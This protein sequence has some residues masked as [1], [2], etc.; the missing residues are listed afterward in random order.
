MKYVW[1]TAIIV[2]T[3][4][5]V[6]AAEIKAVVGDVPIS[7]YDV[8]E[9][10]RL[11]RLQQPSQFQ[12][13]D[14]ANLDK[15][16]LQA[17]IDEYIKRQEA[18]KQGFQVSDTD[19]REAIGRLEQQ[20]NMPAGQM[21]EL[22][23]T[24]DIR[25]ETLHQQVRSDLLW[26][27]ILSKNKASLEVVTN[28]DV[29]RKK[30]ALK[31]ELAKPMYLLAEIVVPTKQEA[32]NIIAD[33]RRGKTFSD[34][35]AQKSKATS[36]G[37]NGLL[38][39]V[40]SDVYSPEVMNAVDALRV[41]EMTSP[42]QVD[43]GWLIVLLLDKQ[44]G[45]DNGEMIIWDLAQL[46]TPKNKTVG[47]IPTVFKMTTCEEFMGFA[48]INAVKG[49]ARRGM[50]DPNQMPPQLKQTLNTQKTGTPIGPIQ[51]EEGDLFFMKCGE[52]K[53]SIL[54]SDEMIRSALEMEKMDKLS[55]KLLRQIKRYV[56]VEY[57]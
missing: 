40:K 8:S 7:E 27:Q 15:K 17:L 48:D 25:L 29:G 21:A 43:G 42:I 57:K 35:A 14:D 51:T 38:G 5:G 24:A 47:Y 45:A 18:E 1:M 44:A 33:I 52:Q 46:A 30:A 13:V 55:E 20:N 2:G 3:A 28:K 11:M 12:G 4:F 49:T 10:V 23:K 32:E 41:N 6:N 22:L 53:Q 56:V 9:R 37:S 50:T 19:V 26:M 39:W 54:P 16:A 34:M 36:A 31:K